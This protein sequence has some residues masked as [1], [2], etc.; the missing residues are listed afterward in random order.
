MAHKKNK[1]ERD[2][3]FQ[4]GYLWCSIC[5]SFKRLSMFSK[6]REESTRNRQYGFYAY[7]C[8]TCINAYNAKNRTNVSKSKMRNRYRDM[9]SHFV[10]K[11]GNSCL[12]CG[13]YD[14]IWAQEF[15]HIFPHEKKESVSVVLNCGDIKRAEREIDKCI[16]LCSNC[17]KSLNKTWTADFVKAN[18]G[19]TMENVVTI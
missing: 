10:K 17:H 9:K 1:L 15:H 2:E 7:K 11:F 13:F 5:K 8:R 14:G 18:Y 3:K 4:K 19:Y 16:M 12:R 6:Y